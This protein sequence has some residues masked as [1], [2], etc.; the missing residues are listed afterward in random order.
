M[1]SGEDEGVDEVEDGVD[2]EVVGL[3]WSVFKVGLIREDVLVFEFLN[4]VYF[5]Q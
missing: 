5:S 1:S 2:G 4:F 3:V